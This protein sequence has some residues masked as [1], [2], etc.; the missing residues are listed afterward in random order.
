[1]MPEKT[2]TQVTARHGFVRLSMSRKEGRLYLVAS[3]AS[4]LT[5]ADNGETVIFCWGGGCFVFCT[6]CFFVSF[7]FSLFLNVARYKRDETRTFNEDE[8]KH[9]A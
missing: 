9:G 8:N 1:M 4:S 7:W 2:T 5:Q 3:K 6:R